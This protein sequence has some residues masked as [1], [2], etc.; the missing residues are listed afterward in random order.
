MFQEA[1]SNNLISIC[2]NK[3]CYL[4]CQLRVPLVI[5]SYNVEKNGNNKKMMMNGAFKCP[6][7]ILKISQLW[8]TIQGRVT[9][10]LSGW[11]FLFW[12]KFYGFRWMNNKRF[13][14][15]T[16]S[17]RLVTTNCVGVLAKLLAVRILIDAE[18][19]IIKWISDTISRRSI[20][21]WQHGDKNLVW[22]DMTRSIDCPVDQV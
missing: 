5:I 3:K 10:F 15:V 20:L 7:I 14:F 9:D 13:Y 16:V 1:H 4:I 11:L 19:L 8:N 2:N 22:I 6:S 21:N 17:K 18:H 12:L